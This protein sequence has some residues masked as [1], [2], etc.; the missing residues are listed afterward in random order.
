MPVPVTPEPGGARR[1]P[2]TPAGSRVPAPGFV[3][4]V[5][6]LP[7]SFP[8]VVPRGA[9]AAPVPVPRPFALS[10]RAAHLRRELE[11]EEI[12]VDPALLVQL[13]VRP[14]LGEPVLGA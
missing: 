10:V 9:L 2:T 3:C 13:V 12:P 8:P 7:P 6:A 11:I 14:L 1:T 5:V 4:S